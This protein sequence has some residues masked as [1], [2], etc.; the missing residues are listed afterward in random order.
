[1]PLF[2]KEFFAKMDHE[3]Y[4][5]RKEAL[6][7][8]QAEIVAYEKELE[9]KRIHAEKEHAKQKIDLIREHQEA[10][11]SLVEHDRTSCDDDCL[12]NG[13][14][15]RDNGC[16]CAKCV[17][18]EVLQGNYPEDMFEFEFNLSVRKVY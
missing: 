3:E 9:E 12:A 17:L 7:K 11:L 4:L 2:T 6:A 16:R 1:M 15:S 8:E 18:M 5:K 13:W 14:G 10:I